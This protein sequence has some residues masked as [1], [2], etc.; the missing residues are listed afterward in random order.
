[1]NATLTDALEDRASAYSNDLLEKVAKWVARLRKRLEDIAT[2]H[3]VASV[4]I[5][6]AT[7]VAVTLIF[8]R[9]AG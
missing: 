9:R 7:D 6:V 2:E 8:A 5:T 4:R 1:M 3:G